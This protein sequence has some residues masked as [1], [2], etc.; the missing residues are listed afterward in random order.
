MTTYQLDL[1]SKSQEKDWCQGAYSNLFSLDQDGQFLATPLNIG[2]TN[3]D[4]KCLSSSPEEAIMTFSV[5]ILEDNDI[6][7]CNVGYD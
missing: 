2:C 3:F 7:M 6:Q 4:C 1:P 5:S